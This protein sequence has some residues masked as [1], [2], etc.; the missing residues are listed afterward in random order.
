[1]NFPNVLIALIFLGAIVACSSDQQ[2]PAQAGTTQPV[3]V[4]QQIELREEI[5]LDKVTEVDLNRGKQIFFRCRA[6]HTL[7]AGG[8][9]SVG[10]NLHGL[11]GAKAA[12]KQGF[13]YS[14]A[15]AASDVVWSD[16]TLDVWIKRP[17]D[18][19]MDTS[20]AFVGIESPSERRALIAYLKK[21]TQ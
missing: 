9:H 17:N 18:L 10:P 20:M 13:V 11:F 2:A 16:S 15:L 6:C 12:Q 8:R 19:V 7:E 21:I 1:M 5:I 3:G 4:E 14:D